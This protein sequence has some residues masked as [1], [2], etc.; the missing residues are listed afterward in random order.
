MLLCATE[1]REQA[2]H[3]GLHAIQNLQL[4]LDISAAIRRRI[5]SRRRDFPSHISS[6]GELAHDI[7]SHTSRAHGTN[8][9]Q[10]LT[11]AFFSVVM[12]NKSLST[13]KWMCLIALA[14]GVAI[15]QLQGA[16]SSSSHTKDGAMD[17]MTGF[18]AVVLACIS[19]RRSIQPAIR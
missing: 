3:N 6:E 11:T 1:Q 10:I 14:V 19:E 12:L 17:R 16:T 7:H 13:K 2:F 5:P 4:K 9:L 18:V 8:S 15:V